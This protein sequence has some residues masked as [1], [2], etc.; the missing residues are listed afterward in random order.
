MSTPQ[1]PPP[2]PP[3][4]PPPQ[5]PPPQGPPPQGPAPGG[6]HGPQSGAAGARGQR[7]HAGEPEPPKR[8]ISVG[9]IL[10]GILL[11]LVVVFIF[12]NTHKVNVRLII[13][14]YR[15]PVALPIVIA[16]VLGALIAWLLRYRRHRRHPSR[17]S[18]K[19][20]A[21]RNA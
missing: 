12:E 21:P 13:P 7:Q 19:Q 15:M 5:G 11:V 16:A 4:G 17:A 2:G 14:Q 8:S 10:G 6:P 18:R 9:Q 20:K 3:Q 1:G